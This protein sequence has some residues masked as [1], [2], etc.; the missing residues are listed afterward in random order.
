MGP[1]TLAPAL[2]TLGVWNSF[3]REV[4]C[5]SEREGES[6]RERVC[7]SKR[8]REGEATPYMLCV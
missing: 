7:V 8:E 6:D 5:V 3:G 2:A 4:V 1:R